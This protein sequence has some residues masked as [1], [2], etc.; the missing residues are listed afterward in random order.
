MSRSLRK[1]CADHWDRAL[2]HKKPAKKAVRKFKGIIQNGGAYKR[3]YDLWG[4]DY[5]Y[6]VEKDDEDY[7]KLKRK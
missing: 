3:L 1:P 5:K 7:E 2:S 4:Y 6:M